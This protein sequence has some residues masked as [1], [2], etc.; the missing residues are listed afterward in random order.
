MIESMIL[1]FLTQSLWHKYPNY[2]V[3]LHSYSQKCGR[4]S[5]SALCDVLSILK[6]LFVNKCEFICLNGWPIFFSIYVTMHLMPHYCRF[7]QIR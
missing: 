4:T 3:K 2:L 1:E 5:S 7:F 6:W